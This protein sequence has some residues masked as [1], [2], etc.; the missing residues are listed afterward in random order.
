M[1]YYLKGLKKM[2]KIIIIA[3]AVTT[4][5]LMSCNSNKTINSDS[6]DID[7]TD[8]SSETDKNDDSG[9]SWS[10]AFGSNKF[11]LIDETTL[12]TTSFT[13][14]IESQEAVIAV[15]DKENIAGFGSPYLLAYYFVSMEK[16]GRNKFGKVVDQ[17]LKDF[18]DKKLDRKGKDTYKKYSSVDVRLDWGTIQMSTPSYGIGKAYLGYV[19]KNNSP[20][21]SITIFPVHNLN[22]K[23]K[24]EE[25]IDS[26]KLTYYLTKAQALALKNFMSDDYLNQY[27]LDDDYGANVD[28]KKAVEK[29]EY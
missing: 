2:K 11:T 15:F 8:V 29:D 5:F 22:E 23:V 19:F 17:Y 25:R 21:F 7:M 27:L 10:K 1:L 18:E 4:L 13:G 24:E 20:Y 9:F 28:D 26:L 12:N 3:T 16:E 6:Y 14:G